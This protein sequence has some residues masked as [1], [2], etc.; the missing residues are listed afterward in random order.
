MQF[1]ITKLQLLEAGKLKVRREYER[2][3]GTT[4]VK[5]KVELSKRLNESRIKV[6]QAQNDAMQAIQG[7]AQ[8]RLGALSQDSKTYDAL[9]QGL[10]VEA[11]YKLGEPKA[12]VQCRKEDVPLLQGL[13]P[14]AAVAFSQKFNKPAPEIEIDGEH[15]LPPAADLGSTGEGFDTCAGGLV[16]TSA[17]GRIVCSNTLDA[18]LAIA[19]SSHLPAIREILFGAV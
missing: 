2:R 10:L 9:L 18:R 14:Q 15:A 3:E 16:V 11:L 7:D 1:N 5:K 12:K 19:Y 6:L 8:T 4:E 13:I 17:D